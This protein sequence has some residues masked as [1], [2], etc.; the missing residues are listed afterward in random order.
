MKAGGVETERPLAGKVVVVTRAAP[1]AGAL[2]DALEAEGARVVLAP[3][4]VIE[5]PADWTPLDAALGRASDY[6][7]IIF[8]SVNGV[9][10]VRRRLG[11]R[12]GGVD[13]LRGSRVAAIGPATA[14]ALAA[15]GLAPELVPEEYVAE[16]LARRLTGVLVP[17]DRVLLPRAAETRDLLVRELT[18]AGAAVD[19]VAAYRTRPAAGTGAVVKAL[20]GRG[21]V[22]VITF[23]S[24]STARHFAALFAPD[25]LAGLM[26]GVR[27]A[28]IG[29]ITRA[30]AAEL[31]LSTAIMPAEYTIPALAAAIASHYAR[32]NRS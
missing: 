31:G 18:A 12:G 4:I 5:P 22:D 14:G 24:S 15:W 3:T 8:T 19:E 11:E 10:M 28:C 1:Q 21:E 30:T 13:V 16:G 25:E 9:E 6:R 17:G 27:V 32:E 29:P 2:R 23:T 20:L 26:R 7:W